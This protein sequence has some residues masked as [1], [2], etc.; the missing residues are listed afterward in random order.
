MFIASCYDLIAICASSGVVGRILY[1]GGAP[2]FSTSKLDDISR[3]ARW[4][5]RPPYWVST[6]CQCDDVV[7]QVEGVQVHGAT[8]QTGEDVAVLPNVF[9]AADSGAAWVLSRTRAEWRD[10]V[11]HFGV[12]SGCRLA[13]RKSFGPRKEFALWSRL[14]SRSA[15]DC[16]VVCGNGESARALR[17]AAALACV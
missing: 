5:R 15:I 14:Q 10:L 16:E 6:R 2:V 8:A 7:A 9:R 17:V 1:R 12:V 11:T 13:R 3:L 4:S